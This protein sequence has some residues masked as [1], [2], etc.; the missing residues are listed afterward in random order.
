MLENFIK[1]SIAAAEKV[2][3][4]CGQCD[5][6]QHPIRTSNSVFHLESPNLEGLRSALVDLGLTHEVINTTVLLV[7]NHALEYAGQADERY[8]HLVQKTMSIES[9]GGPR[10]ELVDERL[11]RTFRSEYS[12]HL[13]RLQERVFAEVRLAASAH[14]TA[15]SQ[16]ASQF[17]SVSSLFL[18]FLLLRC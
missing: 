15:D 18:G 11:R 3:E 7:E 13:S 8:A 5:V 9:F 12:R 16:K 10:D 6:P 17:S 14:S 4:A 1:R 2:I